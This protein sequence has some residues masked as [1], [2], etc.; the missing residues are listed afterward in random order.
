MENYLETASFNLETLLMAFVSGFRLEPEVEVE[1]EVDVEAT[2]I[3]SRLEGSSLEEEVDR[4]TDF[5]DLQLKGENWFLFLGLQ[6][7]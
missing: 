5:F 7:L 2:E 4:V 6:H 1:A 3:I